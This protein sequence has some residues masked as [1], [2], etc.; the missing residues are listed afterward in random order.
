V[1]SGK[2]ASNGAGEKD[3]AAF[4]DLDKT[5]IAKSSTLAFSKPL[6]KA[7]FLNRRALVKAGI[8]QVVYMMV[9]ADHDQIERVRDQMMD[10]TR[11]WDASQIRSIVRETVDE[12]VAPLVFAEALAIMDEHRREGRR[13]VI[14]S[15]SP[16]EVV[17]PLAR[18][19]GVDHV[20]ATRSMIDVHG[21]YTGEMEFYAYGPGKADAIRD[22]A[23]KWDLDL[24]ACYAYSDS[25]TDIPMMEVVGHPVAVNPDRELREAAEKH[26]WPIEEFERPVTLRTRLATLPK[27][28]PI[29]S[30]AAV[31]GAV[32]GA[33]TLWALRS[34]R[35]IA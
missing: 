5:V 34:R 18:Y 28:V 27:P 4:F 32:A 20:I 23:E 11:G 9:G 12:V 26:G 29:I 21:R 6:Y 35:R 7:G 8:A 16:E 13:V 17:M 25:A 30:G 24:E 31:A 15:A 14:I 22:L 33:I 2:S 19:L 10:L 3:A 1:T